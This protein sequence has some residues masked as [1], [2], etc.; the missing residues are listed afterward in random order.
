MSAGLLRRS[1]IFFWS[2][3]SSDAICP[4]SVRE[5]SSCCCF[6]S[7]LVDMHFEPCPHCA[8]RLLS[9]GQAS[10]LICHQA[11]QTWVRSFLPAYLRSCPHIW[12]ASVKSLS[13]LLPCCSLGK[14]HACRPQ[15]VHCSEALGVRS[16]GDGGADHVDPAHPVVK[17]MDCIKPSFIVLGRDQVRGA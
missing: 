6:R 14:G 2:A 8:K 10:M 3:A 5:S 4:G 15:L 16:A 12:Q 11:W 7:G 13:Q 1:D 9:M 17:T